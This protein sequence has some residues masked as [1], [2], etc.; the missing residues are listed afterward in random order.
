MKR[1]INY[2]SCTEIVLWIVSVSVITSCFFIFA[3]NGIMM[4][5]ASLIGVTAIIINAKGNPA[6]QAMMIFFSV[7]YGIISYNF[8]YYGE[9]ITYLGMTAPMAVIA[10]ISWLKNPYGDSREVK[11]NIIKRKEIGFM[12]ILSIIVTIVFGFILKFF[13]TDN[14]IVSTFSV[15]TSFIAVYLAFRR[16][17][18]FSIAYALNDI[19]LIILWGFAVAKDLSSVSILACFMTFL[20]N[21]IYAFISWKKMEIRQSV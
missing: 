1:I 4:L 16:S 18:Y 8:A 9:M 3:R 14:L 17:A 5:I 6:G 12:F 10:L 15:T 11:V 20:A 2:F 21:D 7:L 19:V 13:N